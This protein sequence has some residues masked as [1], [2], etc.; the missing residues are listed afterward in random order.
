M[1]NQ[2]LA[3][4]QRLGVKRVLKCCNSD[5]LIHSDRFHGSLKIVFNKL[6]QQIL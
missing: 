3:T 4:D 2:V 1:E 5:N 6:Q